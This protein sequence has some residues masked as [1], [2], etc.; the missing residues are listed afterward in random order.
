MKQNPTVHPITL[1]KPL[2][3]GAKR[4]RIALVGLPGA[5]KSTLFQSVTSTAPQSGALTGTALPYQTCT[6]QIGMEE[7]SVVDLP[8]LASLL[9]LHDD[10]PSVLQHL[11]WGNERAPVAAHESRAAPAPLEP[12]DVIVQVLDATNLQSQLELSLELSQL[13]RPVVLALNHM[14]EAR[15]KGLRIDTKLL[16]DQLGMP[17]VETV[18]LMGQGIAEL[19]QTAMD[20]ARQGVCPLPQMSSPHIANSL[21]TLGTALKLPDV[22]NAFRVPHSLLLLLLASGHRYFE[23][24]LQAHFPALMAE[25]VGHR[26]LAQSQLPRTLEEEIHADRHHRAATLCEQVLRMGKPQTGRDWRSL[27]DA[28]FLH[29]Q[30]GLLASVLV[31]AGVLWVVFEGSSWIDA[32]TT[33]VIAQAVEDWQPTDT[34]GVVGRAVL[35]GFIG[36]IG[37]VLPYMIPLV[38]SLIALEEAGVMHRIAF[39]VD[40]G[41][42]HIGLHGGVA[43]P[44]LLGLGCN[45]P[46]I[47]AVARNNTG[48]E[49]LIASVLIT[50]VPCSARSAIILA[51][52]GKYLGVLG[53]IG[54]YA[55]TLVLIAVLGRLLSHSTQRNAGPGQVQAIPAYAIPNWHSMLRETWL[56]TSDILTIVTPLLVGGSVV[57]A[58]LH[59][60]DADGVINTAL[61]PLTVWWLGLPLALGL[62]LLFGVLRKELSLLM[63]FQALHTQELNT[64]L[65]TTQITTLLV[66]LT[67]YVPCIST[68]AVMV[69]T[70]GQKEAWWSVMLSVG[71]AL[72][73]SLA[74][75][76]LLELVQV[77]GLA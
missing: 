39:V 25:L 30:W 65:N 71:V 33:Q 21:H 2:R 56:R 54:L 48:R 14:D 49:R 24:E 34:V 10:A 58:L 15:R 47:S 11:L 22:L 26:D 63:I 73:L 7:A 77:S 75:R 28:F 12:P 50:F 4:V 20:V 19:F 57:L 6:V 5:G 43:V 32:H 17:V 51:I 68:F 35:D 31:F 55:L 72:V 9:H 42:H 13:G 23:Q 76:A 74:V 37:I 60:W 44:F 41:F 38:L 64:V 3:R 69:K 61:T 36:L 18:A 62:P 1:H 27:L 52:A 53:V 8:G 40:R 29:P 46:A 70:M 16:S 66:F 67:F 45:V 59:H